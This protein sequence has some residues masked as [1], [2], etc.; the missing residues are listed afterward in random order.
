MIIWCIS[1][2]NLAKAKHLLMHWEYL[3]HHFP[4]LLLCLSLIILEWFITL[5]LY[6]ILQ[7]KV[8][9]KS[10]WSQLLKLWLWWWKT[11]E[12]IQIPWHVLGITT[13]LK[14]EP[15]NGFRVKVS[16]QISLMRLHSKINSSGKIIWYLTSIET[17]GVLKNWRAWLW[18][19]DVSLIFSQ[20]RCR[21]YWK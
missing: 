3:A 11:T 9:L 4:H 15:K 1:C 14:W 18:S 16:K 12:N 7:C 5:L 17:K 20:T 2:R 8:P 6:N 13:F 19:A 10:G 21:F